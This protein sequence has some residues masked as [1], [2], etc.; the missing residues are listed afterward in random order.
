MRAIH[1]SSPTSLFFNSPAERVALA[2]RQY[3]EEGLAPSG[4][5]SQ[6]VFQSWARC[7][8]LHSGPSDKVVF[9]PVTASRA[10][11][12]L[13]KNRLLHAA[14]VEGLPQL[15]G[16]LGRT[17]C[18]AMLTD[19]TGVLIGATCVGRS[20]ENLMPVATRTGV[21][22]SEEAVGT[23]APGVVARTGQ[24]VRVD[25]AEHFFDDVRHMHCAAAPILDVHGR[26]AGVLDISSEDIPFNF[27]AGSL[28]SVYAAAIENRLLVSQSNNHLVVR[29]QADPSLVDSPMAALIGIGSD[30]RLAWT[31]RAAAL[32]LGAAEASTGV[33]SGL[34]DTGLVASTTELASL[35]D[36]TNSVLLL[37]NGLVVW[38]RAVMRAPDGHRNLYSGF[39][40][41]ALA[42]EPS[43]QDSVQADADPVHLTSRDAAAAP[44]RETP[45]ISS[46][47]GAAHLGS[48]RDSGHALIHETLERCGGNIARAAAQLG[49]SR[50]LI[51]RRLRRGRAG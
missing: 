16:V 43:P 48:L 40:P 5:V 30:G 28:V 39:S 29:F 20:H 42:I 4:I 51:Y 21:N 1:S 26:L 9:Q 18:A 2:R 24:P 50:G 41:N 19:A 35:S 11:L 17:F 49:V 10:N 33:S 36:Q 46:S 47:G 38:A 37:A 27:D 45:E 23:T 34:E 15:Q 3:F 25:G 8:R 32:L 31:N 7:Q 14:W 12:A 22:L 44:D 13:Q 6:A